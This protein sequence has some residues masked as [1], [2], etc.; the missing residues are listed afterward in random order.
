MFLLVI[1][2]RLGKT[3]FVT[4]TFLKMSFST[5]FSQWLSLVEVKTCQPTAPQLTSRQLCR[6]IYNQLILAILKTKVIKYSNDYLLVTLKYRHLCTN[7]LPLTIMVA[8]KSL[9]RYI[10]AD[11]SCWYSIPFLKSGVWQPETCS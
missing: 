5:L 6:D 3:H 1:Y 10:Q 8:N 7:K 11:N 2:S 9:L 4:E